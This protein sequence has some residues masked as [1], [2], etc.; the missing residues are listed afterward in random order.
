MKLTTVLVLSVLTSLARDSD[1]GDVR[2][3]LISTNK[4]EP[5]SPRGL[6]DDRRTR[7]K[8]RGLPPSDN[9]RCDAFKCRAWVPIPQ[10]APMRASGRACLV[11]A[12]REVKDKGTF[13]YIDRSI[14]TKAAPTAAA[15][16]PA[17][18]GTVGACAA[19]FGD[20]SPLP[21]F[22]DLVRTVKPAVVS[23]R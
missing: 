13:G 18:T 20:R 17:I 1:R 9:N 12:A 19:A 10:T 22:V 3:V 4:V 14:P 8:P 11:E 7:T 21:N 23:V 16:L 2:A 15:Q 5:G 6:F